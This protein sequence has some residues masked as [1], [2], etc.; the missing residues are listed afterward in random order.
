MS[1]IIRGTGSSIPE[2]T[3]TNDKLKEIFDTSDEWIKTRTGIRERHIIGREGLL[4]HS[5]ISAKNALDNAGINGEQLDFILFSSLQGEYIT[6]ATACLI[7]AEIKAS[8]TCF[9]CDINMGC[10]GFIYALDIADSYFKS[11]KAKCGLIVCGEYMSRMVDWN[12]RSSAIL[13]GDGS[14]AVVLTSGD[15]CKTIGVNVMGG[16]EHLNIPALSGNCPFTYEETEENKKSIV[17]MNGQEIYKFAV[18]AIISDITEALNKT[19]LSANDIDYY[20][21]HQANIRILESVWNKLKISKDKVPV[22][23]DKY[24]NTSSATIPIL[25]DE[26]NRNG[27]LK[28]GNRLMFSAFGAGL[29][30]GYAILEWRR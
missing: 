3:I 25:L 21:L 26:L 11:G 2:L 23:I 12:D 30:T 9:V 29:A 5:V 6:P 14:G 15:G 28:D 24:G 7:A 10:S 19:G 20:I 22:S 13:F 1:F 27:I 4:Y 18:S 8:K 17:Y 16:A